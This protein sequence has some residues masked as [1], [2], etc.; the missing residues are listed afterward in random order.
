MN[1]LLRQLQIHLGQKLNAIHN[2]PYFRDFS[3]L[4]MARMA[5]ASVSKTF[6]SKTVVLQQ[7]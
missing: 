3:R 1:Q 7:G 2:I 4:S 5:Y 6:A